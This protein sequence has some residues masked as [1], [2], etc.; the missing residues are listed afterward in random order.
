MRTCPN[1]HD[2]P[3][4]DHFC[5]ECGALTVRNAELCAQGHVNSERHKFCGDCGAPL[6]PPPALGHGD[7]AGH[8]WVDPT[9]RHDFRYF[10]GSTWTEHV[11]DVGGG[12]FGI[13]PP[14]P[15]RA[16]SRASIDIVIGVIVLIVVVGAISAVALLFSRS[17]Q[18]A[19]GNVDA[20]RSVGP[21]TAAPPAQFLPTPTT[22]RPLAVIGAPCTPSAVIGVQKDGNPAY[23]E[24]LPDSN[25]Y[26]WSMYWGDIESPYS[27]DEEPSDREDPNIA[28]CMMQTGLSREACRAEIP[29]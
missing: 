21:I 6:T 18:T 27:S 26:M 11:S 15:A 4:D 13:D 3:D 22:Y 12:T 2:L 8:W 19:M 1:G 28:V 10:S 29:Q 9:H 20:Q 14:P 24:R 7:S 5:G 16:R 23:C 25:T 17:G